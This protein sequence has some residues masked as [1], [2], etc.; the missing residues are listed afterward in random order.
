MRKKWFILILLI[1]LVYKNSAA[2]EA[3]KT[4]DTYPL[5][6]EK[7]IQLVLKH[8]IELLQQRLGPRIT[9]TEIETEKAEFDSSLSLEATSEEEA[10]P[11]ASPG[12]AGGDKLEKNR[13]TVEAGLE[14]KFSSGGRIKLG[15]ETTRY[16]SNS[17]WQILNPY[18]DAELSLNLEQ[19]LL[20]GFGSEVTEAQIEIAVN[21]QLISIAELKQDLLE[22]LRQAHKSYWNLIYQ[23]ENLEVKKTLLAQAQDL[24]ENNKARAEVGLIAKLEVLEAEAEVAARKQHVMVARHDLENVEDDLKRLTSLIGDPSTR[25]VELI[26]TTTPQTKLQELSVEENFKLSLEHRPEYDFAL[27]ELANASVGLRVAED[28]KKPA[29]DLLAGGGLNGLDRG[30]NQTWDELSTGEYWN[31]SVG[32]EFSYPLGNRQ[33]ESRY[34]K[35]SLKKQEAELKLK[36]LEQR[37]FVQ[38][39]GATRLVYTAWALIQST[40][41]AQILEEEKLRM[42]QEKFDL[43]LATSH[44]LLEYQADLAT[45]SVNRLKAVVGYN[46]ALADLDA[47]LGITL[48]KCNV[49]FQE[50]SPPSEGS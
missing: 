17:F 29:L 26:P 23:Q 42:Q 46:N 35:Q 20:K 34:I 36:D 14:K 16:K 8:N 49:H 33:A 2:G 45:A 38:V 21:D 47:V 48:I 1:V 31:W 13:R 50:L 27:A 9:A 43:G 15:Y 39:R 41:V 12:F 32:L 6:L 5:S 19:P 25:D 7:C 24:L 22:V 11:S 18:Y 40:K 30:Y 4:S 3:N 28:D 37:L 10:T 44:D